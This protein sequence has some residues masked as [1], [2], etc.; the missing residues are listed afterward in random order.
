VAEDPDG[1]KDVE[2]ISVPEL[3]KDGFSGLDY[4]TGTASSRLNQRVSVYGVSD[5]CVAGLKPFLLS[6][7][8]VDAGQFV[9][10]APPEVKVFLAGRGDHEVASVAVELDEGAVPPISVKASLREVERCRRS[11]TGIRGVTIYPLFVV[12]GVVRAAR[13]RG[14]LGNRVRSHVLVATRI[15]YIRDAGIGEMFSRGMVQKFIDNADQL[16]R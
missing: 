6:W 10:I 2:L 11:A 4:L 9:E 3:S 12:T 8:I 15:R 14:P 13:W 5:T 1:P 16:A 7:P